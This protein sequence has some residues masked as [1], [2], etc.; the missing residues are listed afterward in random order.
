MKGR[1]IT[2]MTNLAATYKCLGRHTEGEKLQIQA[3]EAQS[4]VFA[5]EHFHKIHT[6]YNVKE[7]QESQ[8]PDAWSILPD[9]IINPEEKG[10][11]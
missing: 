11:Q 8:V 3:Q 7:C 6:M 1:V 9:R 2:A 10:V 5:G 4:R